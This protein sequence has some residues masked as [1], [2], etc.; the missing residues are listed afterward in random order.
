MDTVNYTI[1][2]SVDGCL[3]PDNTAFIH[4]E[5]SGPA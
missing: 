3:F 4:L 1:G 2:A 5:G